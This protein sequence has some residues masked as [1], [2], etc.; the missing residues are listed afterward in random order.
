MCIY[1]ERMTKFIE[2]YNTEEVDKKYYDGDS[3]NDEGIVL[4]LRNILMIY[5]GT[6]KCF[7]R[8]IARECDVILSDHIFKKNYV[9][10]KDEQK[11]AINEDI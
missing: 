10:K 5:P 11:E 8:M 1:R 2:R 3:L 7:R 9:Y 4:Y 6:V